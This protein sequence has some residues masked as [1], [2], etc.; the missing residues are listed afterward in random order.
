M[1]KAELVKRSPLRILEKSTQG[2]VAAG[3]LGIIASARGVGKTACLV[4]IATDQ[5][6]QGKHVIHVSFAGRIDHIMTWYETIF[7]E[8]AKQKNLDSATEI[9]DDLIK[10][11]VI[12]NFNQDGVSIDQLKK[13]LKALIGDGHFNAEIIVIDGYDFIKGKPE[14]IAALKNFAKEQK[15]SIWMTADVNPA[16]TGKDGVPPELG[17]YLNDTCVLITLQSHGDHIVLR[18]VKDHD[19]LVGEELNLRLDAKTLLIDEGK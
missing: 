12:M 14:F 18:L 7:G 16:K 11:R 2:G 5:L 6:F 4:H 3:N 1:V 15:L 17:T 10:N 9:H 19:K 8:I 13:S